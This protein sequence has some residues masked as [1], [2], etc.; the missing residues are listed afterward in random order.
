MQKGL[1]IFSKR[2]LQ[3]ARFIA[4]FSYCVTDI[5][6]AAS[7]PMI[8][9]SSIPAFTA[10]VPSPSWSK[11]DVSDMAAIRLNFFDL[12]AKFQRNVGPKRGLPFPFS[13]IFIH[14]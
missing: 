4:P 5:F 14:D 8:F 6:G 11:T 10:H 2:Y 13:V 12:F 7:P 3:S 9:S 1:V